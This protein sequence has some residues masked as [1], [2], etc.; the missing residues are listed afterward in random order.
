MLATAFATVSA[1]VAAAF[2]MAPSS[3]AATS[4]SRCCPTRVRRRF[5][6][7]VSR[8][9]ATIAE[10]FSASIAGDTAEDGGRDDSAED[11]REWED[12][13]RDEVGARALS[14]V[15]TFRIAS[16]PPPEASTVEVTAPLLA[17][18]TP[19]F[20]PL[21]ATVPPSLRNRNAGGGM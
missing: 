17:L 7:G 6:S 1:A 5:A 4:F 19:L 8:M 10:L 14:A 15:S 3:T 20:M 2:V 16:T 21:F 9:L 12:G 18:L 13:T 11:G